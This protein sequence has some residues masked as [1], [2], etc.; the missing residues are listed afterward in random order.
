MEIHKRLHAW[1]ARYPGNPEYISDYD[2]YYI[3]EQQARTIL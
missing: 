3:T 1:I 2:P